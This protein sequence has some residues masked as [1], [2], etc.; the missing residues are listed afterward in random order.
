[1]WKNLRG[2][3]ALQEHTEIDEKDGQ[4]D[5]GNWRVNCHH[6]NHDE[7][8][9]AGISENGQASNLPEAKT[10]SDG[11]DAECRANANVT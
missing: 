6:G 10:L 5:D 11:D 2:G 9:R 3:Q 7:L 1:M 8:T 4:R